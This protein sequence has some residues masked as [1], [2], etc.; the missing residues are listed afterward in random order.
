MVFAPPGIGSGTTDRAVGM[1]QTGTLGKISATGVNYLGYITSGADFT[2]LLSKTKTTQECSIKITGLNLASNV[3][4]FTVCSQPI[5][6]KLGSDSA[7][8]LDGDKINDLNLKFTDVWINRAELTIKSLS[9]VA[10][11]SSHN[12][13]VRVAAIKFNFKKNLTAGATG[14]DVKELQKFLNAA[15]FIIAKSGPGAS[16]KE[17]STFG[18]SSRTALIKFQKAKK[19][20]PAI[21]Y[22]GPATRKVINAL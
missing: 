9:D 7:I 8:D 6:L 19:I 12:P 11:T 1:G 22:F 5:T 18:S 20:K 16:G 2:A 17:T 21:G 4:D 13:T 10:N 15:G 14:P 3:I